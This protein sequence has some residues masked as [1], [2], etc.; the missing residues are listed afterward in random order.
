MAQ[1]LGILGDEWA[2]QTV[3]EGTLKTDDLLDAFSEVLVGHIGKRRMPEERLVSRAQKLAARMR[4][5]KA[6]P[7]E[8]AEAEDVLSALFL[9]L[10]GIAPL[11]CYF[12][13]MDGDGACYGFWLDASDERDQ[14]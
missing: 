13:S 3:S 14:T 6:K 2:G 7:H 4:L 8:L 12:G 11:G 1:E 9:C 5:G 10:A